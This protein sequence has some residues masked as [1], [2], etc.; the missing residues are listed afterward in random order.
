MTPSRTGVHSITARS[1][2][3]A[4]TG[5]SRRIC[6]H[7]GQTNPRQSRVSRALPVGEAP[8]HTRAN[9]A[10]VAP[11][12]G[13]LPIRPRG[14]CT[15]TGFSYW[16]CEV[17]EGVNVGRIGGPPRVCGSSTGVD[18]S[19]IFAYQARVLRRLDRRVAG[20]LR[21]ALD[22]LGGRRP[23]A[24][25]PPVPSSEPSRAERVAGGA[26]V[27][28]EVLADSREG[29]LRKA[30]RDDRGRQ[31][32][33]N[34]KTRFCERDS[35]SRTGPRM[36]GWPRQT[37]MS[38]RRST[39]SPVATAYALERRRRSTS[40]CAPRRAPGS[41]R[42]GACSTRWP[43]PRRDLP[44]RGLR[45]GRDDAADGPARRD[46][47]P[48]HGG[49]RRRAALR[50]GVG[51]AA[52]RRPSPGAPGGHPARAGLRHLQLRRAACARVHGGVSPRRRRCV[53][54]RALPRAR[55]RP[56]AG[57]VRAGGDRDASRTAGIAGLRFSTSSAG[58]SKPS[59]AYRPHGRPCRRDAHA[60]GRVT[61]CAARA[62]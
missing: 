55:R 51:D 14:R 13:L 52:R 60:S 7:F 22:R 53:L 56:P 21:R 48:R 49:R 8:R 3:A 1:S 62:A 61:W 39:L 37:R 10:P 24:G 54:G 6:G 38:D 50:A 28:R 43:S 33:Q 31:T 34:R 19:A 9:Q 59:S 25:A 47:G 2:P 4:D 44:G 35:V 11:P 40:A 12:R 29:H 17:D 58:N 32:N 30:D 41:R 26:M 36:P 23:L 42:P 18:D 45:P 27:E 57:A 15:A 20:V 16:S 46:I 5:P